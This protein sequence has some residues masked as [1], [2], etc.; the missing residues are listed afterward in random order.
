[1]VFAIFWILAAIFLLLVIFEKKLV[2]FEDKYEERK[3]KKCSTKTKKMKAAEVHQRA[4]ELLCEDLTEAKKQLIEK[5]A[6]IKSL[7]GFNEMQLNLIAD[8]CKETADL[9]REL[10]KYESDSEDVDAEFKAFKQQA[11]A[12]G[13]ITAIKAAEMSDELLLLIDDLEAFMDK[14]HKYAAEGKV[15]PNCIIAALRY[16]QM[17]RG[18]LKS[19]SN[20]WESNL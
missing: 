10:K 2:A 20:K 17:L 4:M 18:S 14:V 19:F 12:L 9:K 1:M 16:F 5:D 7:K 15:S 11:V 13:D 8:F 6:D 3:K